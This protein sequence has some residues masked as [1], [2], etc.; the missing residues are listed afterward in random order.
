MSAEEIRRVEAPTCVV[1]V[2]IAGEY[3]DAVAS[4]RRQC[5]EDGLCVTVTPTTFVYTGGAETGVA[6]GFINY[7]RFPK[8]SVEIEAR[9]IAVAERLMRDLCQ[10]SASV[11][12]PTSTVWLTRRKEDAK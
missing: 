8:P 10:L 9:A 5:L 12:G 7:P 2:Y 3:A 6:V 1:T 11:V 4:L